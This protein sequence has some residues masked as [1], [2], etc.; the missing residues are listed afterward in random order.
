MPQ[1]YSSSYHY[2]IMLQDLDNLVL[3]QKCYLTIMF[4][5]FKEILYYLFCIVLG[6]IKL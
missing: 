2:I 5:N 3:C 4:V 1:T 6:H